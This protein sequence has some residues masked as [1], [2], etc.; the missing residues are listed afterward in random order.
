MQTSAKTND[1]TGTI[2]VTVDEAAT[3]IALE[4][5]R[6][7]LA[8]VPDGI[9][10]AMKAAASRAVQKLQSGSNAAIRE[11][12]DITDANIRT[13]KNVKV[14]YSY[15]NGVRAVV[16]FSGHKIPLYRFGGSAPKMPTPDTSEGLKWVKSHKA[17]RQFYQGVT[18]RGH[19][20]KSTSPSPQVSDAYEGFTAQMKSGHIGLFERTGGETSYG[21]DQ[22]REIMGNSVAQMVGNQEVAEKLTEKAYTDFEDELNKAVYRIL[23]GWR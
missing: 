2:T 9:D 17:W 6:A 21:S 20:F 5:A 18:A 7:L 11:K 15:P 19:Q 1:V 4:R 14:R 3:G 16:T 22:I 23:T 10:K 13:E 12:Y 8:N